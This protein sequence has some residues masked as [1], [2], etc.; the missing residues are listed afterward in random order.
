MTLNRKQNDDRSLFENKLHNVCFISKHHSVPSSSSLSFEFPF[1]K[2]INVTEIT[3]MTQSTGGHKHEY[4]KLKDIIAMFPVKPGELKQVNTYGI[5]KAYD[6]QKNEIVLMDETYASHPVIINTLYDPN[7]IRKASN[8]LRKKDPARK[9]Y[10]LPCK[11]GDI[12]RIH[13][14]HLR[15]DYTCQS[16]KAADLVVFRN[17]KEKDVIPMHL[18]SN[19]SFSESDIERVKQLQKLGTEQLMRAEVKLFHSAFTQE[20]FLI[21]NTAFQV[22]AVQKLDN[23]HVIVCWNGKPFFEYPC[24]KSVPLD[25]ISEKL[26]LSKSTTEIY[27]E[28]YVRRLYEAEKLVYITVFGEVHRL[29]ANKLKSLDTIAIYNLVVKPD[30]F[31]FGKYSF[32]VFESEKFGRAIRLCSSKSKIAVVLQKQIE[33]DFYFNDDFADNSLMSLEISKISAPSRPNNAEEEQQATPQ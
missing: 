17:F 33:E 23:R 3:S 29:T 30:K 2:Y 22:L 26:K 7:H 24:H 32:L 18:S 9:S 14:I 15:R 27:T 28:D 31:Y 16:F 6:K 8:R 20:N 12:I 4:C 5:I 13:R 21:S 19:P 10:R 11:T 25:I 1:S